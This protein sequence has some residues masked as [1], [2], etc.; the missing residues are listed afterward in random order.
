MAK[1]VK[2]GISPEGYH[3]LI[4]ELV[5]KIKETERKFSK[6][7]G[8]PR[9]GS[10]IAVYLSHYLNIPIAD[11]VFDQTTL[12]VDDIADTGKTLKPY[13]EAFFTATLHYKS[14]SIVTPDIYIKKVENKD[15]IVYPYEM[16]SEIPNRE[17]PNK[18][19]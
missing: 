2:W 10:I 16:S 8:I 9:G 18:P 12:I 19:T 7:Y 17:L 3:N 13:S 11:I 5:K 14:R 1:W 15:W 6:V 4:L